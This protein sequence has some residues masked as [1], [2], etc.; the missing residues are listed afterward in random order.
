M[1]ESRDRFVRPVDI[2]T[3]FAQKRSGTLGILRD[4]PEQ[5]SD[6]L[7]SAVTRL[8]NTTA[9]RGQSIGGGLGTPRSAFGHRRRNV[10][11][12]TSATRGRMGREN[13]P[14]GSTRRGSFALPAWYP[15]T[16]L[17]DITA[18]VRVIFLFSLF[19]Y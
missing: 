5:S 17:R 19:S 3:V 6:Q 11:G 10:Y 13:A 2:A 7:E 9:A 8:A 14:T 1:P 4:E 16:P 12:F 18:V 15:R